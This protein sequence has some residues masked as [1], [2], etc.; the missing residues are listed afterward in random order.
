MTEEVFKSLMKR[1][2]RKK[3]ELCR[4]HH[5]DERLR[6]DRQLLY[7]QLLKQNVDLREAHEKSLS[8]M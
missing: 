3:E 1:S 6:Q 4:D 7:E 8:E 2:S 5:R